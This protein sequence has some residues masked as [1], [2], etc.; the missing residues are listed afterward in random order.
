[1]NFPELNF[2]AKGHPLQ[3]A[4][5]QALQADEPELQDVHPVSLLAIILYK[6]LT[7]LKITYPNANATI[8]YV[9]IS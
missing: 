4:E 6:Y 3:D 7:N 9:R 8:M 2:P 5:L 1:M